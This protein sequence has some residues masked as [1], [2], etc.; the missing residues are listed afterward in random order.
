MSNRSSRKLATGLVG[1]RSTAIA[2]CAAGR[3]PVFWADDSATDGHA[4][5]TGTVD[6]TL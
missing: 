3:R 4:I 6:C 5:R 1:I 2:E